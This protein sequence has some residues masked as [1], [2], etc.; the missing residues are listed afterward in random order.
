MKSNRP[1]LLDV[2]LLIALAWP[3]HI[4][5]EGAQ[6]WS[7][8]KRRTGFRTFLMKQ[9]GFVRILSSPRFSPAAVAPAHALA[10]L[11]QI[12]NLPEHKFWAGD[13]SFHEALSNV[14]PLLASHRQ[15]TDAYL[16]GLALAH[17]GILA[18]L[19]RGAAVLSSS[20]ELVHSA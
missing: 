16:V 6:A 19:D 5:H 8:R 9:A 7:A 1:Y 18:T 2:N 17:E 14:R 13:C 15:V 3:T 10:L 12:T 4:H 11:T 20:V